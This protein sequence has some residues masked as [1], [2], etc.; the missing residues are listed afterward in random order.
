MSHQ[1]LL[2]VSGTIPADLDAHVKA[3]QRPQADYRVMAAQFGADLLDYPAAR[4]ASGLIGKLMERVGGPDLMLAWACF[5]LRK[6]YRV[7][8]TDGEQIGL[9]L[10]AMFK[11]LGF[12]RRPRHLMIVHIISVPKKMIFLD[13]LRVQSQIDRFLVYAT[14]Q[15]QFIE[16]RWKIP[17]QRVVLTPFMV[18]S[19]FF[20][21][22]KV[23][24]QQSEPMICAVG[25]ERRDYPTLLKAVAGLPAKVVIAAASPWSK[26]SDSTQGQM[27]P[28]N[29]EVRR[30]SQHELRQLY[31]DSRFLVMPLE[32]VEFQAG[33]T[34]IL[35]AMAMERAVICSRTPG[36][37][38]AVVDEVTGI[39]VSPSDPV[40]L[41]A[42]LERLLNQ[43]E[44]A[45]RMGK[46]GRQRIEQQMSLHH[47]A[48]GLTRHVREAEMQG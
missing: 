42:A 34:A 4:K 2:T 3:G 47:Y 19:D 28:A 45:T 12:G 29:V 40:A 48:A 21:P 14:A 5:T 44:V 38:D 10:A 7:I 17:P 23:Q 31:A 22:S 27:I 35:E 39:Y 20:A 1:V 25:L 9:P 16:R 33:I 41:R 26:R 11:F 37:T 36:Q 6:R 32:N 46:A 24:A 18:D 30:F 13:R 43:P 8:V 15:K